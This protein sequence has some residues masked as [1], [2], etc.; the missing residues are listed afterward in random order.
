MI[1][2]MKSQPHFANLNFFLSFQRAMMFMCGEMEAVVSKYHTLF[3]SLSASSSNPA[4]NITDCGKKILDV[5]QGDH[6]DSFGLIP[7]SALFGLGLNCC[8]D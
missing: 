2:S 5:E 1:S 6:H 3:L 7:F 4:G 8:M